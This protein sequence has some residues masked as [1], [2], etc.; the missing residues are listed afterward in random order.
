MRLTGKGGNQTVRGSRIAA[1]QRQQSAGDRTFVPAVVA[2]DDFIPVVARDQ[3]EGLVG[4][5]DRVVRL[6]RVRQ[7]DAIDAGVENL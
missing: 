2:P 5:D 3:L 6:I 7:C 1:N 4:V